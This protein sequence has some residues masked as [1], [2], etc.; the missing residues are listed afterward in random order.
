MLGGEREKLLG[1]Q[2]DLVRAGG[3]RAKRTGRLPGHQGAVVRAETQLA[4]G[5]LGR[6]VHLDEDDPRAGGVAG[7]Q[8]TAT[9]RTDHG[10]EERR[11]VTTQHGPQRTE[12]HRVDH[13]AGHDLLEELGLVL[14]ALG[15]ELEL[16]GEQGP[17][18]RHGV[19][20]GETVLLVRW[21]VGWS[22]RLPS[23]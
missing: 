12:V 3:A 16:L 11:E 14:G 10:L 17:A 1:I 13:G 15:V 7:G 23:F 19:G 6:Q 18:G 2:T 4:L 21:A 22:H 9:D 8:G 5:D 20:V